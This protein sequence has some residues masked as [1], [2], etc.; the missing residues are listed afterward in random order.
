MYSLFVI[1]SEETKR[2]LVSQ[3]NETSRLEKTVNNV[4]AQVKNLENI[5]NDIKNRARYVE[6]TVQDLGRTTANLQNWT[7]NLMIGKFFKRIIMN[8][9]TFNTY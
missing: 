7:D 3:A 9:D 4:T 5:T 2:Q 1:E 8:F 6:T